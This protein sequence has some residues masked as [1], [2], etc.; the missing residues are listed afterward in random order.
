MGI[1]GSRVRLGSVLTRLSE[2]AVGVSFVLIVVTH[3]TQVI[4]HFHSHSHSH[5]RSDS[6]TLFY[7]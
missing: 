7:E 3:G 4:P 6:T 1:G 2:I 5:S